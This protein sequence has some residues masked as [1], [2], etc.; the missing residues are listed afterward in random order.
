MAIR[1]RPRNHIR[2]IVSAM[3]H[4]VSLH[5]RR[6]YQDNLAT[7][8]I[9]FI[10]FHARQGLC[11]NTGTVHDD[12]GGGTSICSLDGGE[13]MPHK[14]HAVLL[15]EPAEKILNVFGSIERQGGEGYAKLDAGWEF[16]ARQLS[17]LLPGQ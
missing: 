4:N 13:S 14:V 15:L 17:E 16:L 5:A 3:A 11:R 9:A 1:T 2:L 6:F 10:I 12:F 8:G 7:G